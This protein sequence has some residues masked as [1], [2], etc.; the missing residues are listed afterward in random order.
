[1]LVR[2]RIHPQPRVDIEGAYGGEPTVV[3]GVVAIVAARSCGLHTA[4][5]PPGRGSDLTHHLM[6]IDYVRPLAAADRRDQTAS[7]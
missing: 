3:P 2:H 4:D 7:A 6:L 5:V 1:L